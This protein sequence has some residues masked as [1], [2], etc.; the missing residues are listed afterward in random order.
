MKKKGLSLSEQISD[1]SNPTPIEAVDDFL[2]DDTS[3]RV[4]D[5]SSEEEDE[6]GALAALSRP[7]ALRKKNALAGLEDDSRYKGSKTSRRNWLDQDWDHG[8]DVGEGDGDDDVEEEEE[9]EEEESE[10]DDIAEQ[11]K[12]MSQKFQQIAK[13]LAKHEDDSLV[14]SDDDGEMNDEEDD[15]DNDDDDDE[16]DDNDD[17]DD[18]EDLEEEE[19]SDDEDENETEDS[20]VAGFS[21]GSLT[22][23]VD[24]G[25]AVKA[26]LGLWDSFMEARIKL[27][28][29]LGLANQLPQPDTMEA[30]QQEGG[31]EVNALI[32]SSQKE[33][34]RL[35]TSLTSLQDILLEQNPETQHIVTGEV[36]GKETTPNNKSDDEDEDEEILSDTDEED[37]DS[38]DQPKG[39][40]VNGHDQGSKV[41]DPARGTS[42]KRKLDAGEDVGEQL[43][44][45]HK[46][47]T[48]YRN[49]TIQ[50]WYEK[51][52]L[53]TGKMSKKSFSGF[54]RSALV[55]IQQ[56]LQD[57]SRL[58][59]RT[60][61][62]R[63]EYTV[64]GQQPRDEEKEE[65]KEETNRDLPTSANQHLKHYDEE[66]FDDDD[67]YHQLLRE[68][69][70]K[71][72]SSTTDPIQLTRQWLQVQKLRSKVKRQVDTKASKGRKI[73]YDVHQKL[74]SF[75]APREDSFMSTEA[76]SELFKSLFGQNAFESS[77]EVTR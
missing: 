51:T 34:C 72:T 53:S 60:Q 12:E 9:E 61:L 77:P 32:K 1:L 54:E 69:I 14:D 29:A 57:K 58:I 48:P 22:D 36:P 73:R 27:Q 52:R 59:Q 56:I 40:N 67:F 50:K 25:K 45:R 55:Q 47:F 19:E 4:V 44:K 49:S 43:A 63:S 21:Q 64:L 75:M 26:Q 46:S 30:F 16:G 17:T 42:R 28:K 41:S 74:V 39:Q 66:I 31:A 33:L 3:A 20:G 7:S 6:G 37:E 10:D 13:K 35:L 71:R 5:Y 24:K 76:R 23:E 11:Q 65:E 8:D 62:R 15:D 18:D 68:L 38:S 2:D 70:E